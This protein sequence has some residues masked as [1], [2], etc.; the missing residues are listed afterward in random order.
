M[1]NILTKLRRLVGAA[2]MFPQTHYLRTPTLRATLLELSRVRVF[3]IPS[4]FPVLLTA[5]R[6]LRCSHCVENLSTLGQLLFLH[7]REQIPALR[8]GDTI[9]HLSVDLDGA[10]NQAAP[11]GRLLE[12]GR[13]HRQSNVWLVFWLSISAISR[14]PARYE[15]HSDVH[16]WQLG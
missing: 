13:L 15:L 8:F 3:S 11:R 6:L 2:C 12:T 5:F 16:A 1:V 7:I 14:E 4:Y 9:F 10:A